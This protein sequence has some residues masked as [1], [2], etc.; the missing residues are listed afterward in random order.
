MKARGYC[1]TVRL[2]LVPRPSLRIP[3]GAKDIGGSVVPQEVT[4]EVMTQQPEPELRKGKRNRTPKNFGPKFHNEVLRCCFLE[5]A[6]NDEMDSIMGNNTWVLA[7]LP[8]GIDYIDTYAPVARIST[9]RLLIAMVLIH[10][11]VIHQMDVK[12]AFLNGE[13]DEEAPKQC[14]QKID[15]VILSSGY[16]LIQV[17][18]CMYSKL[19]ECGKGVIIC[20]YVDDMLIFGTNQASKKQTY[21]TSSTMESKFMALATAGKKAECGNCALS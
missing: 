15:E 7:D 21:I 4:E 8:L 10:N 6:I 9:I 20:L 1:E 14:H 2:S 18:K 17:D 12:A 13:L 5:E 11:L 3:N 16:L 19:D